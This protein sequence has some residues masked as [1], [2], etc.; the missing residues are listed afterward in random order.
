MAPPGTAPVRSTAVPAHE[1]FF[2]SEFLG[3]PVRDVAREPVGKIR[4]LAVSTG[5]KSPFP[6]ITGLLLRDRFETFVLPWE[7]VA[8]FQRGTVR[9]RLMKDDLLHR[10]PDEDEILLARHLLD[11]QIVD[12]NGV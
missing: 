6:K 4:D 10:P 7:D 11:K 3:E 12:I 5:V 8:I 1:G 2:L 9:T